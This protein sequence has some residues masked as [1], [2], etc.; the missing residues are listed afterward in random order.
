MRRII[1]G[2][3]VNYMLG[4]EDRRSKETLRIQLTAEER[5]TLLSSVVS[6]IEYRRRAIRYKKR[7]VKGYRDIDETKY[8]EEIKKLKRIEKKLNRSM[9]KT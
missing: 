4:L 1:N 6:E 5:W 7:N 2:K 3:V 8:K 9:W